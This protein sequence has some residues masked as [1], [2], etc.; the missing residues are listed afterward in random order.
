MLLTKWGDG[1]VRH[2]SV[3]GLESFLVIWIFPK[4]DLLFTEISSM[5]IDT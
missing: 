5:Q 4:N 2:P 1:Q 3:A